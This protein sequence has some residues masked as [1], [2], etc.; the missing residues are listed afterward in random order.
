V[1]QTWALLS[2]RLRA[3]RNLPE[4]VEVWRPTRTTDSEGGF[5]EAFTRV[6]TLP[7]R[8]DRMDESAAQIAERLGQRASAVIVLPHDADV[9]AG[10]ELRIGTHAYSFVGSDVGVTRPVTLSVT[11][12]EA[13]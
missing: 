1:R 2:K 13:R 11:V 6:A 8:V 10:D 9:I 4:V 12:A 7:G 5:T 3:Q